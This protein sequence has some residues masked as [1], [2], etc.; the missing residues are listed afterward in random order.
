MKK[1]LS[2]LLVCIFV[3]LM[4]LCAYADESVVDNGT[5]NYYLEYLC[6]R[7]KD[8]Q[9]GD[10]YAYYNFE[11]SVDKKI[12][13]YK[14]LTNNGYR[15]ELHLYAY[16]DDLNIIDL[17]SDFG[18]VKQYLNCSFTNDY[19]KEGKA[20]YEGNREYSFT[21]LSS[22]G[23]SGSIISLN[24]LGAN[25][26]ENGFL[27]T[28]IPYFSSKDECMAYINGEIGAESALNSID[29]V[30]HAYDSERVPLPL[31]FKILYEN[32][33]Y[34]LVWEYSSED[35]EKI[36]QVKIDVINEKFYARVHTLKDYIENP[37][38]YEINFSNIYEPQLANKI[39]ITK[40]VNGLREYIEEKYYKHDLQ[41]EIHFTLEG[42]WEL[43][44]VKILHSNKVHAVMTIEKSDE[45][46][47]VT[48]CESYITDKDNNVLDDYYLL[49]PPKEINVGYI[50]GD[51]GTFLGYLFNGF[52]LLGD[53]GFLACCKAIFG[54]FPSFVWDLLSA[55][56]SAAIVIFLIKLLFH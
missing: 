45:G 34:Y 28:N 53:N 8:S 5:Y 30:E 37:I 36:S 22:V 14:N 2:I 23:V 7:N 52:G 51:S 42:I 20:K 41:F 12:C 46:G 9:Y 48:D 3:L 33:R 21:S 40:E 6:C 54:C 50:S 56:L 4:P 35:L 1:I 27:S 44:D 39:D 15:C 55:G 38:D 43:S 49:G 32:S 18:F 13:G 11:F 24:T 16:D 31:D 29:I 19:V 25:F 10:S 47:L 26:E 17:H